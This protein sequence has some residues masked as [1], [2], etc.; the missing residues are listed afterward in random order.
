MDLSPAVTRGA[1][2]AARCAG[3]WEIFTGKFMKPRGFDMFL[4]YYHENLN[5]KPMVIYHEIWGASEVKFAV[6]SNP[7]RL[8]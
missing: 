3:G 6:L 2:S 5:R 4:L 1:E 7:M 8:K